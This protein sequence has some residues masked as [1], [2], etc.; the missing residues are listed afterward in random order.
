MTETAKPRQQQQIRNTYKLNKSLVAIGT[1]IALSV[2]DLPEWL[3]ELDELLLGALPRQIP[4][5]QHLRRRLRV[6]ELR[7]P[8]RRRHPLCPI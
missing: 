2:N 6:A 7:L 1:D 8:R 5:V 4:Q 3:A